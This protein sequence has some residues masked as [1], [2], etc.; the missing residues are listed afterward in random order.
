M[1]RL[2][3]SQTARS[4]GTGSHGVTSGLPA[5]RPVT[6]R[7]RHL[8]RIAAGF[9]TGLLLVMVMRWMLA[10]F[11]LVNATW[12]AP[13]WGYI[14]LPENLA[15]FAIA[16]GDWV[17]FTPPVDAPWPYV[18]QVRGMAG[19]VITVHP[20]RMVTVGGV[21]VGIATA[22]SSTGRPVEAIAPGIIPDGRLFLAGPHPDSHDSR[23]AEI[24]LIPVSAVTAR[25]LPLPDIPWLGLEGPVITPE[26][27]E[28]GRP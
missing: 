8:R 9:V 19:D 12:S 11:L 7:G 18:K 23:Y 10:S 3:T 17:A 4:H 14:R 16:H 6:G 15:P 5:S 26:Q 28:G 24:G 22:R 2:F 13:H 21:P 1:I 20:D 27:A 25:L